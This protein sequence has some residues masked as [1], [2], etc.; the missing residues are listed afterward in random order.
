MIQVTLS[1]LSFALVGILF[2]GL[3]IPLIRNRVPPNRFYGFRTAKTLS[4]PKI[5]YEVNH[6][7]GND[8]LVAGA[9]VTCS[10][11]TMFA[12]AQAWN[13]QHVALTLLL[14]MSFSLVGVLLHGLIVMRR[15]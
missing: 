2:I 4:D 10:S 11:V 3:S 7:S 9:L 15:M 5:W 8:L 13:P 6:I 1:T 14:I 12:L